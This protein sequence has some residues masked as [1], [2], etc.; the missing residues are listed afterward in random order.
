MS[1]PTYEEEKARLELLPRAERFE[2][3]LDFP[4]EHTFKVIGAPQA[5]E[6]RAQALLAAQGHAAPRI[7]E[8]ASKTGK[9]ISLSITVQVT[10]GAELDRLYS[11]LEGIEGLKAL[12]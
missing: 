12:F 9:Y 2:E 6:E 1:K 5:L 8:K 11:A 4:C 3:L 7:S 10:S